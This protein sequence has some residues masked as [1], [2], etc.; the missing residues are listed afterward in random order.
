MT[1][2]GAA[3]FWLTVFLDYPAGEFD[4]GVGFWCAA[5]GYAL[6]VPRGES[7]EFATLVPP[8]GDDFLKVQRLGDGA[9]RLHLDVH[10]DDPWSRA[11]ALEAAGGELVEESPHGYV[12]MRSPAGFTFCL[13]RHPSSRVAPVTRWPAG[14]HSRVSRFC[15]DV[16]RK[17]YAEEVAFFQELLGGEWV[18]VDE[19]ET[20]LRPAA[21]WP[22]D[23]RLQP[24]EVASTVTSHLHIATDD[25]A[26]E[27]ERLESSG[28]RARAV[29]TG[30]AILE[31]PGGSALCVVEI[32]ADELP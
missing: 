20:A 15:L 4:A 23:V 17:R 2:S 29:R 11:E 27:V 3:P 8:S 5:T 30:K 26:A 16:P 6:S 22:L 13:V 1:A 12:V 25:L 31:A 24:A 19:P 7:G 18:E 9:T 14:H 21:G 32:S 10:V 28:A